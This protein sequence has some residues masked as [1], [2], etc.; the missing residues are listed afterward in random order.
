MPIARPA[1]ADIGYAQERMPPMSTLSA[2]VLPILIMDPFGNP[3]VF[4]GVLKEV[5]P[6]RRGGRGLLSQHRDD[7][8]SR[9]DNRR[10]PVRE[11]TV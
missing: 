5:Q 2:T 11:G 8:R 3:L 1:R 6:E 10:R 4:V 9:N 7:H